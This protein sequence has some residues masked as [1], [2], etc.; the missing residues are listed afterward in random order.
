MTRYEKV[1]KAYEFLTENEQ[2]GDSF[3]IAELAIATEW[4]QG[5]CRTY[6]SKRW[7]QYIHRD[8]SEYTP[9]GIIF[10]SKEE[11]RAVHSQKLQQVKDLSEKGRL[12][13]KAKEFAL[14]AVSTYNNPFTEF[15][16]HGYIVNIVIAYTALFHAIFE[17]RGIDYFYKDRDGSPKLIDGEPKA[18]ELSTC[19]KK[20]W[21]GTNH[22]EKYNID[23]LIGL[24]N[25]I[26]HRSLPLIDMAV[27]GYCQS[28]L[29]NFE[30]MLI[31][32]F[33]EEHTLMASLAV[34]MQLTRTSTQQQADALKEF[35]KENYKVVREFM[36]T[37][38]N[39]LS[40]EI[41]D[42]HRYRLR[43]FLIPKIG[44][45]K[46]S[47]DLAIEFINATSL[48]D[49]QKENYEH[50]IALIKG[51]DSPYKL[52]PGQVEKLVK[53]K[54][55][56]FNMSLHTKCWKR[57]EAR[58]QDIQ[59]NFKGEYSG[60]VEGFDGYLYSKKWADFLISE[61]KNSAKKRAARN[62]RG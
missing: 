49:E 45:S 58:P 38:N 14:L 54:I 27:S 55:S 32:E 12:V 4:S 51:V 10:L 22:P 61:L 43:A 28:A 52:R 17:K 34:S 24:R 53:E 56:D 2:S 39:D 16:T 31:D 15:K 29:T 26:E 48:N 9:S 3:T 19:C 37:F 59:L 47:A 60:Y 20:Y 44:G 1:D 42:S 8:K 11:F 30:S 41:A 13:K 7:H 23:F 21:I 25:R 18:W 6:V 50:A 40:D 57:Y 35:Q 5:S 62:Y 46:S 36:E 33:G